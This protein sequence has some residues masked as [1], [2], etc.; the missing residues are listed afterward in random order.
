MTDNHTHILPGMD[1]GSKSPEMSLK[2]LQMELDQGVDTVVLTSHCY[3]D[4]EKPKD[5]LARRST[6]FEILQEAIE[7]NQV[8][9]PRLL[10]GAEVAWAPHLSEWDELEQLCCQGTR[11]LLLE[12]PFRPWSHSMIDQIYD[13]MEKRDVTPVF[14][15][16]ERYI[17]D[18][19]ADHI[20]EIISMGTPIQIS[21]AP[22]L[23]FMSRH[24]LVKMVKNH[25]AHL[26]ASDCHNLTTRPPNLKP[27]LDV[28]RR[29]TGEHEV[30]RLTMNADSL[31]EKWKKHRN[32]ACEHK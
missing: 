4:R 17:K 18:Q 11:N 12:M 27:G 16:L 32:P 30:R 31:V 23:K 25:T 5:Y 13:M 6:S 22:L 2:M 26:L 15:H 19:R 1:D 8:A 21:A 24:L 9:V 7:K 20:R 28:V 14:A 29:L 3:R 10:L